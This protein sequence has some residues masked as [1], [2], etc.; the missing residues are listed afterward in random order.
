MPNAVRTRR[1]CAQARLE[2]GVNVAVS[3]FSTSPISLLTGAAV[4]DDRTER[5]RAL[6]IW[7]ETLPPDTEAIGPQRYSPWSMMCAPMSPSASDPFRL[8][9]P[10]QRPRGSQA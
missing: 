6:A 5:K 3:S 2:P 10:R 1:R 9:P 4:P 7:I 8:E